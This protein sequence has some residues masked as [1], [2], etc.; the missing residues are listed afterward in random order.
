MGEEYAKEYASS[1]QEINKLNKN[2]ETMSILET[3]LRSDLLQ[4]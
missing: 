1:R 3:Q 4:L 2:L